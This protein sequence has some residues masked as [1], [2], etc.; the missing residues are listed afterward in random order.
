VSRLCD[1]YEVDHNSNITRISVYEHFKQFCQYQ[2]LDLIS[3]TQFGKALKS[4][5]NSQVTTRRLG[6]RGQS[7]YP[8]SSC[9]LLSLSLTIPLIIHVNI[10]MS[11]YH[12]SGIK[13][14]NRLASKNTTISPNLLYVILQDF[15]FCL[16]NIQQNIEYALTIGSRN[17]FI[18]TLPSANSLPYL[19]Q[20]QSEQHHE[21]EFISLLHTHYSS[22]ICQAI[23][24]NF[25][26]LL[27]FIHK[28]WSTVAI[29]QI[30]WFET[31]KEASNLIIETDVVF[32]NVSP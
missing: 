24:G 32:Y 13:L 15:T 30:S 31:S 22:L 29:C 4:S 6:G 12:Y 1:T 26:L 16:L 20:Q 2:T 8:I 7:R 28:F 14:R 17:T 10:N 27:E 18:G 21:V 9:P 23:Q 25:T 11:R 3:H 19:K 5:F